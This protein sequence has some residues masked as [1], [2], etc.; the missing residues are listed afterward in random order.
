MDTKGS[1]YS[2]GTEYS[3]EV[4]Q[5]APAAPQSSSPSTAPGSFYQDGT[6]YDALASADTVLAQMQALEDAAQAN[7]TASAASASSASGSA[8]AS[9]NSAAASQASAVVAT[10]QANAASTSA[11]AALASQNAAHASEVAAASSATSASTSAGTATTQAGIATTQATNASNSAAAA[12]ASQNAAHTSET[13]AAASAATA[14]TQAGNATSQAT[15]AANSASAALTSAGNASTSATNAGNSATSAASSASTATTQAG[16]ASTSATNAANSATSA[17]GSASTA[18]TQATNAAT[19]ASNAAASATAAAAKL[20]EFKGTYYGPLA[21]DPSLDPNGN[22]PNAGDFYFNTSL[23]PPRF[24]SY[25]GTVWSDLVGGGGGVTDADYLVKTANTGL[26]AERVVTDTTTLVW[27]WSTAGVVKANVQLGTTATTAAAGNDSRFTSAVVDTRLSSNVPLKNAANA[28]TAANTFSGNV[29]INA[30]TFVSGVGSNSWTY[31]TA[32]SGAH[33][34][35]TTS[36]AGSYPHNPPNTGMPFWFLASD[37]GAAGYSFHRAGAYAMNHGLGSNN[38]LYWGGWSD[39]VGVVRA[40][41]GPGGDLSVSYSVSC[42]GQPAYASGAVGA[43][44]AAKAWVNF[45]GPSLAIRAGYNVSSIARITT[46]QYTVNFSNPMADTN[47]T[48]L[49]WY[50]GTT[51]WSGAYCQ[52]YMGARTTTSLNVASLNT[53]GAS[54]QDWAYTSLVI[55]R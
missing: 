8:T 20:A 26:S 19:S 17:S 37:A 21:S 25:D 34:F 2:G 46:G 33:Q 29:I 40:Y 13:N 6:M 32:N 52:G 43:I 10:S 18:T 7:A 24:R 1:F 5:N 36:G 51:N 44:N 54:Y 4:A 30:G 38:Y 42:A 39:G 31:G 12:L 48:A 15:N 45:D 11:S 49:Y 47:F 9:A 28:F 53:S 50:G 22:A 14:T 41:L 3:E 27:D 16:N 55:F 23:T 35:T